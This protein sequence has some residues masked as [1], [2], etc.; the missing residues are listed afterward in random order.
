[1]LLPFLEWIESKVRVGI[2]VSC[3]HLRP[4]FDH[5]TIERIEEQTR[6]KETD[7]NFSKS[8][9]ND[10]TSSIRHD[11]YSTNQTGNEILGDSHF[12][13]RLSYLEIS[14]NY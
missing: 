1:M 9:A 7:L 3:A 6:T 4:M 14:P 2:W 11:V 8:Q 13:C 5:S 12:V 10:Q